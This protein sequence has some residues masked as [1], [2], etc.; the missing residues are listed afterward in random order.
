MKRIEEFAIT[1]KSYLRQRWSRDDIGVMMLESTSPRPSWNVIVGLRSYI[2]HCN[3]GKPEQWMQSA[4]WIARK[5]EEQMT[6]TSNAIEQA[7]PST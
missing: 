6:D 5:I 7:S 2:V 3:P 1:L 4:Q